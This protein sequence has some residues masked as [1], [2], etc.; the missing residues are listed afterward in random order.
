MRILI[1]FFIILGS[2]CHEELRSSTNLNDFEALPSWDLSHAELRTWTNLNG[3][4]I[5]AELISNEKG[6]VKLKH[7]FGILKIS[8]N[9]LSNEDRE[10]L[11]CLA[12]PEGV[13][14]DE[15]ERREVLTYRKGSNALYSGVAFTLHSNGKRKSEAIYKDGL[16]NGVIKSWY[17]NGKKAAEANSK[18]GKLHGVQKGWYS[19]GVKQEE[20]NFK[21]GKLHGLKIGWHSNGNKAAEAN[22][23]H[24]KKHGLETEWFPSGEKKMEMNFNNGKI[25]GTWITW[26]ENGTK[27]A[28]STFDY[29][30]PLS[31]KGWN[32]KGEL[33]LS[34]K[35]TDYTPVGTAN[36]AEI[37]KREDGLHYKRG[38]E[39]PYSGKVYEASFYYGNKRKEGNFKNGL[40]DG[41]WIEWDESQRKISQIPYREGKLHGISLHWGPVNRE[42][43]RY[44]YE[45]GEEIELPEKTAGLVNLSELTSGID[46]FSGE[47]FSLHHSNGEKL[48]QGK[49]VEGKRDGVWLEWD[50]M[51]VKKYELT[52]S[53]GRLLRSLAWKENQKKP[54]KGIINGSGILKRWHDNG[55]L[56]VEKKY[57]DGNE[58]VIRSWDSDGKFLRSRFSDYYMNLDMETEIT[59]RR[60]EFAKE[61]ILIIEKTISQI[62]NETSKEKVK[63]YHENDYLE[64]SELEKKL[65][66]IK[67]E[68]SSIKEIKEQWDKEAKAE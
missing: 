43:Y 2:V 18:E 22:F 33:K 54:E 57:I 48:Q 9:N 27:S 38:D 62:R 8:V 12:K 63:K 39:S 36:F 1:L 11:S 65:I 20:S 41:L 51:G 29:G 40:K 23:Q 6:I 17:S 24:G 46:G 55:K 34:K 44:N 30:K 52:Y 67:A 49:L 66:Q 25:D 4:K 42:L 19:S 5:E 61:D 47:V 14:E 68:M 3:M 28:E 26:N 37:E 50:D 10:F 59:E 53:S 60:I 7:K 21:E 58:L 15:L 45:N 35:E 16:L 31:F 56:A 13:N 64:L 32:E